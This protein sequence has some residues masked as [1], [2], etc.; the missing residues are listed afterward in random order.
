MTDLQFVSSDEKKNFSIG[1]FP[2]NSDIPSSEDMLIL[3]RGSKT[4]LLCHNC[5]LNRNKFAMNK[6]G[7]ERSL[8]HTEKR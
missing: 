1:L 5:L 4:F 8:Q 6:R 7:A 3:R 2:Y